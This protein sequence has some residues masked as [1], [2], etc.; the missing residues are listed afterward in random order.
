MTLGILDF[1]LLCYNKA[2]GSVVQIQLLHSHRDG[3]VSLLRIFNKTP[4]LGNKIQQLVVVEAGG[5]ERLWLWARRHD[6]YTMPDIRERGQLIMKQ[7]GMSHR[8]LIL[9]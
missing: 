3:N 7:R 9:L 8:H 1:G 2:R 5:G 6:T 4:K